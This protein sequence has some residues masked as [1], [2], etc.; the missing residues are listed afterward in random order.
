MV[1]GRD[2]E[3]RAVMYDA[4]RWNRVQQSPGDF[5]QFSSAKRGDWVIPKEHRPSCES[6]ATRV[7]TEVLE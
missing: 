1:A 2:S 3:S 5:G 6:S 4:E 7:D